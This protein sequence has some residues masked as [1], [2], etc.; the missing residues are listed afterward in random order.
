[1]VTKVEDAGMSLFVP[2]R[3]F[4]AAERNYVYSLVEVSLVVVAAIKDVKY[5]ETLSIKYL[6]LSMKF[7]HRHLTI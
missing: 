7:P 6:Y 2:A 3:D 4:P 5:I 1:M